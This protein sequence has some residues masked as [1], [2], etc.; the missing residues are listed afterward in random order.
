MHRRQ[1]FPSQ[2]PHVLS[3]SFKAQMITKFKFFAKVYRLIDI[4]KFLRKKTEKIFFADV[5]LYAKWTESANIP[6]NTDKKS[7]AF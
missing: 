1:R 5:T 2:E 6:K 4:S 7:S 3:S